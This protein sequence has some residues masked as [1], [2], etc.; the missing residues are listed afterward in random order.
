MSSPTSSKE[1]RR[2][3]FYPFGDDRDDNLDSCDLFELELCNF[4]DIDEFD[5]LV[6]NDADK[7]WN[8]ERERIVEWLY[9]ADSPCLVD[10]T[11]PD[12]HEDYLSENAFARRRRFRAHF[13]VLLNH[14]VQDLDDPDY[15]GKASRAWHAMSFD[16]RGTLLV[17]V[18]AEFERNPNAQGGRAP[19]RGFNLLPEFTVANLCRD[20]GEGFL[21][22]L[23]LV[24]RSVVSVERLE[25][26]PI[27][28]E[29]FF[30]KFGIASSSQAKPL[31]KADRAFQT[32]NCMRRHMVLFGMINVLLERLSGN[33][34]P[35]ESHSVGNTASEL[36][37]AVDDAEAS[38][39]TAL[40]SSLQD[41]PDLAV[42]RC[43]ACGATAADVGRTRLLCCSKCRTIGRFQLYCSPNCQRIDWK[44]HRSEERCGC[45]LSVL[46]GIT[47][48][49][50]PARPP[51]LLESLRAR[52]LCALEENP[53]DVWVTSVTG[54]LCTFDGMTYEDEDVNRQAR[55]LAALRDLSLR[56]LKSNDRTAVDLLAYADARR[57]P[58]M[59][60]VPLPR[61]A[62]N[63]GRNG[64]PHPNEQIPMTDEE[65]RED[66]FRK[67]FELD[68]ERAWRAACARGKAE[69]LKPGNASVKE[70]DLRRRQTRI[71]RL[72]EGLKTEFGDGSVGI[73]IALAAAWAICFE[74][75]PGPLEDSLRRALA[76]YEIARHRAS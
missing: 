49:S 7:A 57:S 15:L 38:S 9:D 26:H 14:V 23:D 31:S 65:R 33:D 47:P 6:P 2:P 64:S 18:A 70:Y 20:E 53:E 3:P 1:G 28:N 42:E 58:P 46:E 72:R 56:A 12:Q 68:D 44:K 55:I 35:M 67:M 4:A 13:A 50:T 62:P 40:R 30:R 76:R 25:T 60:R 59:D 51:T 69:M 16:A 41:L 29:A 71:D 45:P 61:A 19:D 24:K 32:E 8:T 52:T 22:L 63:G 5:R 21:R 39:P 54:R 27:F 48:I 43:A 37:I 36:G 74:E 34:E 73:E 17:R 11:Y 66:E 75:E 10:P